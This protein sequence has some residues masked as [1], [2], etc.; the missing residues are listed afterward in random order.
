MV[1]LFCDTNTVTDT[2]ALSQHILDS[3]PLDFSAFMD[4][5][6]IAIDFTIIRRIILKSTLDKWMRN[7][8]QRSTL[9]VEN[10]LAGLQKRKTA[11]QEEKTA[12][13]EAEENSE[14]GVGGDNVT[15]NSSV[16]L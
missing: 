1:A 4:T 11:Y 15:V 10:Y 7:N 2:T 9:A 13:R 5:F 16:G 14:R 8:V 12:D 3:I 6:S